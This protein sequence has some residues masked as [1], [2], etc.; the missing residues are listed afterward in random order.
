MY[1]SCKKLSYDSETWPMAIEAEVEHEI[2][3][4]QQ[5]LKIYF[6][7]TLSNLE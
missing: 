4:L 5:F 2:R 6:L 7:E 3:L 1:K